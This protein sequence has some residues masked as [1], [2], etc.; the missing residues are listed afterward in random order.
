MTNDG[1]V[2][3]MWTVIGLVAVVGGVG[4]MAALVAL[5]KATPY[6]D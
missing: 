3:I 1:V 4:S 5:I 6:R 2:A